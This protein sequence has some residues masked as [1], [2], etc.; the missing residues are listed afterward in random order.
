MNRQTTDVLLNLLCLVP[1]LL[2]L[3][4]VFAIDHSL[5]NGVVTGKYAWFLK[6][7]IPTV[8]ATMVSFIM[9]RKST[10]FCMADLLVLAFGILNISVTFLADKYISLKLSFFCLCVILYFLFRIFLSQN[11]NNIHFLCLYLIITAIIESVWG[12]GQLYGIL[13]SNH[14]IFNITGSFFNPGPYGGYIAMSMPMSFYFILKDWGVLKQSKKKLDFISI[15]WFASCLS[16]ILSL[17]VLP[18]TMSRASWLAAISGCTIALILNFGHTHKE[19]LVFALTKHKTKIGLF[20]GSFLVLASIGLYGIYHLKKNS[21]D[22]RFFIWKISSYI[23]KDNPTGIGIGH[24]A[25]V[26]GNAQ[27]DYFSQR[28]GNDLEKYI[29]ENPDYAFN[30]LIQISAESGILGIILFIVMFISFLYRGYKNRRY[31]IICSLIA[32]L[33]FSLMSYPFNLL[34]F[35]IVFVFLSAICASESSTRSINKFR[36]SS[37]III[38]TVT[39]FIVIGVTISK[40]KEITAHKDWNTA[41]TLYNV[42]GYAKSCEVYA[43]L[44]PLLREQPAFLFEYG[45]SLSQ[46]RK[47]K[48][49]N[50]ILTEAT[51]FSADPMIYN[52]IGKNYQEMKD[53]EKAEQY[54]FKAS[55]IVPSRL[56]PYYLL[57]KLYHE[58]GEKSKETEM[59]KIILNKKVKI[60]SPAIERM[61]REMMSIE[62]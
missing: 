39:A 32:V 18:A 47:Y 6:M 58:T 62:K 5:V 10:R 23:V 11:K 48:E 43:Q 56:Y 12:I 16:F 36:T 22:G 21:A 3:S 45:Q 2:I 44:Y 20:F 24:F 25:A 38:L 27:A 53:Y 15:R 7:I 9:H 50:I 31:G 8:A 42:G 34:P 17:I 57:A 33:I 46:T 30:D 4:T 13:S 55:H 49:S 60:N 59:A 41:K 51:Q 40:Y 54:F 1:F 52:I 29:A 28:K 37:V 14:H 19:Y 61:K 26:Y 35:V